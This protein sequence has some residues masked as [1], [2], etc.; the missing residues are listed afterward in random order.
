MIGVFAGVFLLS[1]NQ[2]FRIGADITAAPKD[3]RVS[4]ITN[5]S[6]T[7]SWTSDK[8]TS[9][10]INWGES[11]GSTNKI[12]KESESQEKFFTHAI[13]LSGL[14][15]GTSYFYKI[16]SDGNNFD[17]QGIPW[18]F[19]TGPELNVN[20]NSMVISGSVIKASGQAAK[21]ALVYMTVDGYLAS[22][23][24][25]D[26]GNFVFQLANIRTSGLNAFAIISSSQTLLDISVVGGPDGVSSAKVFPQSAKPIPPIIL[27]QI[28]DF[29]SLAPNDS[30]QIPNSTLSLPEDATKESKFSVS[31][32]SGTPSPTSVILES[33]NEGEVVTSTKPAFFGRGP[34]GETIVIKVESEVPITQTMEIAKD[35]TWTWSPPTDLATGAHKVTIS[36]VDSTGITRNL[37]RD[38]VVQAGE[39]PSFE[40]TPSQTLATPTASGTATPKATIKPTASAS[41]APVPVTG[42][43]T[44]TYLLSIM[45]IAVIAFSFFVWRMSEN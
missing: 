42:S 13:N 23:L 27:G 16:N 45:G 10:F 37:T 9:N 35:G 29:R 33:I 36:W 18:Q 7:I 39:A 31:Q 34:A 38:F 32:T 5:N 41:A 44:Y 40:A 21:R 24:T 3:I 8:A 1:M 43:L 4:N 14:K 25:S 20:P 17:N 6:A 11:A 2:V 22:T 19:T 30:T 28:F 26:T 15:P 12:E